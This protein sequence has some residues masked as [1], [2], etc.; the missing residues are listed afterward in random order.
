MVLTE[1]KPGPNNEQRFIIFRTF[2]AIFFFEMLF[3]TFKIIDEVLIFR[4]FESLNPI[5]GKL[6]GSTA[7]SVMLESKLQDSTLGK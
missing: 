7:K 1:D 2:K 5:D 3:K 4:T 6:T